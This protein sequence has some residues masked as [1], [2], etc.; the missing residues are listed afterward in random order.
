[1]PQEAEHMVDPSSFSELEQLL[2]MAAVVHGLDSSTDLDYANASRVV[3]QA[4]EWAGLMD[5]EVRAAWED[6][7]TEYHPVISRCYATLIRMIR[8]VDAGTPPE[9]P[10]EALFEGSGNFGTPEK[11]HAYPHFTSCRLTLA[12]ERIARQ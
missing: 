4:L 3:G 11:P 7:G 8:R 9:R 6:P 10:G 5:E 1:M 12:G 2:L